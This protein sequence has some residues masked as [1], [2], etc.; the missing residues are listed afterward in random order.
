[1]SFVENNENEQLL[2]RE[3]RLSIVMSLSMCV[4]QCNFLCVSVCLFA[5]ISPE[6]HA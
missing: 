1:V 4:Y 5:R 3:R 6:P 2:P